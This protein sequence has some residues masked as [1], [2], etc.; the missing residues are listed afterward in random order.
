MAGMIKSIF[1]LQPSDV[2]AQQQKQQQEL[3]KLQVAQGT[4]PAI[5]SFGTSFGAGLGRGLMKG[6]GMQDPAMQEAEAKKLRKE[7]YENALRSIDTSTE[8]GAL[9]MANLQNQLGN[10][11]VAVQFL[12]QA[13]K[14]K[15]N[16][17]AAQERGLEKERSNKALEII[18]SIPIN[19]ANPI[20]DLKKQYTALRNANLAE[21]AT[22]VLEDIKLLS[23]GDGDG[24]GVKLSAG[25]KNKVSELSDEAFAFSDSS[26]ELLSLASQYETIDPASGI[27]ASVD[28][29]LKSLLGT[30]DAVTELRARFNNIRANVTMQNLPPGAASDKDVELVLSG[31]LSANANPQ[32]VAS[33]LR[34]LA[35]ISRFKAERSNFVSNF[36]EQSGQSAGAYEEW[37]VKG[38]EQFMKKYGNLFEKKKEEE[39]GAGNGLPQGF[40]VPEEET[41][42]ERF[43]PSFLKDLF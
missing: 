16:R 25:Q 6:F 5:A 27:A 19:E 42:L 7:Q 4:D 43:T 14:I 36:I 41:P 31:F 15:K 40:V 2:R 24:S 37:N 33:F 21:A 20:P 8:Q 34:G 13:D 9:Q 29:G 30:E 3:V 38:K 10:S 1:G 23:T 17:L 39:E 26:D 35:K 22:E 12:Q 18:N 28:E 32:T 11:A